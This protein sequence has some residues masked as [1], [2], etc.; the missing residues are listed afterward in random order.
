VPLPN[1]LP[2]NPLRWEGWKKYNSP[3]FYERLCLEFDSNAGP[4]QIE[5]NCRQLLIWWQKKLPLKNQ[6]SNPIAQ[7]LRTGLDEAPVFL[8]EARTE[9]LNPESRARLDAELHARAVEAAMEEFRKILSFAVADKKLL[10]ESE[11]RLYTAGKEIGLGEQDIKK[12]IDAELERLGAVRAEAPPPPP[13]PAPVAATPAAVAAKAHAAAVPTEADP[14]SEFR[15]MLRLSRLCLDGEEMTDDQRDALCNMGEGLGLSGGEAEDL[16]DE[17]LEEVSEGGGALPQTP[18]KTVAPP[19][20]PKTVV[21]APRAAAAPATA[22]PASKDPVINT[23]PIARTQEKMK[24]PSFANSLGIEML[25]VTSGTFQ[26]GSEQPE[27]APHER[28]ITPVTIG[29][30]Y[31]AQFPVTNSQYEQFDKG[32]VTKR[33]PW[34]D[35][36]HPVVYVSSKEAEK[37]CQWLSAKEGR[38]YRLPTEAEWDF[39]AR[40]MEGRTYPW[41]E[42]FDAG[43]YANFADRRTSFPWRDPVLDDGYA[44]TSPVGA[45][46][47]GASPFGM[48]DMAGNVFEWCLDYFENYPGKP[49]VNRRGPTQGQ[50]RIYRGGSWKSK[51]GSLR[52]SARHFNMADYSSNDVGFRI[53]CECE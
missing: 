45:F 35:G 36:Q 24:Y 50:R 8:V 21:I 10:P 32:H 2:D 4:E 47:R 48:E 5:D 29:C 44:E 6:P 11:K 52:A 3:N 22:P 41:G 25:L 15:R 39:A 23:S 49:R 9:L 13:P 43:H 17:Y 42:T 16:I 40:G 30:F 26:M 18:V 14:Q 51:A 46:P 7:V 27:A 34:A 37:F 53:V 12:A 28:P 33:A 1:P 20:K 38:T 31:F 19:V